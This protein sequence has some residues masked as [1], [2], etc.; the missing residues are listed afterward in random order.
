M[1]LADA[2]EPRAHPDLSLPDPGM[3]SSFGLLNATDSK[4]HVTASDRYA[5]TQIHT[6]L[7]QRSTVVD[8]NL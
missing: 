5:M 4:G 8:Q 3:L 6:V 7:L 2:A 1:V